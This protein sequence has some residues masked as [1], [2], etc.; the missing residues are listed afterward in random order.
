MAGPPA[1]VP[2]GAQL[3]G[4]SQPWQPGTRMILRLPAALCS[5]KIIHGGFSRVRAFTKEAAGVQLQVGPAED[6]PSFPSS[7]AR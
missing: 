4:L 6:I 1:T 7:W 5:P 2:L 3:H